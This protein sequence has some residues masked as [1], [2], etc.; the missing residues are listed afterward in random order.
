MDNKTEALDKIILDMEEIK[1]DVGYISL[2]L[3]NDQKK[4]DEVLDILES[5]KI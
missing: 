1:K 5:I 2:A 3:T 4:L